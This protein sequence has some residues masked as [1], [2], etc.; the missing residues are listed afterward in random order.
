MKRKQYQRRRQVRKAACF[1]V[2]SLVIG[3]VI[4][5]AWTYPRY[6][7]DMQAARERLLAGSQL[8]QTKAGPI[9]YT[10]T[11]DGPPV[12]IVHGA[13]GG[14]DQGLFIAKTFVGDGYRFI[15]PSRFGHLRTPLPVDGSL[16]AQA[17][18][19]AA[20][21][22]ALNIPQVAVLGFSDGGPSSLQFALRYP[23]RCLA[24]GMLAAKSHT[25]PP[26]TALQAVTFNTIFRSDYLYWLITENARPFLLSTFGLP[27][28]VRNRLAPDEKEAL[29]EFLRS[30]HPMS[31]RRAGIYNDRKELRI[32]SSEVFPLE[33]ITVPILIIHAKDDSLQPFTHAQYLADHNAGARLVAFERGG[34]LLVGHHDEVRATVVDFFNEHLP[35]GSTR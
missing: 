17:D 2:G 33:R 9:E 12:L 7:T 10:E 16:V 21:L 19:Y 34:H 28:E 26:D 11:G 20:L 30:M 29:N 24:L 18:A 32:L 15:I 31:L 6:T 25:P 35:A 4:Y 27:E 23:E 22:D 13:G 3:S 5:I 8:I 1:I 14:Y